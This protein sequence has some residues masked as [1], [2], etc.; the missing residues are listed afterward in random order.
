MSRVGICTVNYRS[1]NSIAVLLSSLN[2]VLEIEECKICIVDNSD[3]RDQLESI[4]DRFGSKL[5]VHLVNSGHNVGFGAGNNIGSDILINEFDCSILW[6]VNPDIE[7]V[8]MDLARLRD[9]V[10]SG[11]E[12]GIWGTV[13]TEPNRAPRAGISRLSTLTGMIVGR[14]D[15]V[16]PPKSSLE[17]VN[18]NSMVVRAE[19]WARLA[20]FSQDYFL[21]FEEP[22]LAKRV[23]KL[24]FCLASTRSI[25]VNHGQGVTTG[26]NADE[27]SHVS[28]KYTSQSAVIF[29]RKYYPARLPIVIGIRLY[30]SVLVARK[31]I[32]AA[33]AILSGLISGVFRRL[34]R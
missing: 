9:D 21:Y 1:A 3:E 2:G 34:N 25:E 7:I 17:F 27:W 13:V 28:L 32:R 24:S 14:D 18:G 31:D 23:E 5:D 19:L 16:S 10:T 33:T 29:F 26:A 20:G 8:S 22:D 11:V 30:H 6:F 15:S 4:V 12:V